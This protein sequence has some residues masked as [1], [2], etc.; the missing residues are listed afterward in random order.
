MSVH[1][2]A[3]T[4]R[5]YAEITHLASPRGHT[6]PKPIFLCSPTTHVGS[7]RCRYFRA[8]SLANHGGSLI[9]SQ[10]FIP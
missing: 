4:T 3:T 10:T 5:C 8:S 7:F 1:I 9:I 2:R 6:D